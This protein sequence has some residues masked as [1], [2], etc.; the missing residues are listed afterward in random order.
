M[1]PFI[2]VAICFCRVMFYLSQ[3]KTM[4]LIFRDF[5]RMTEIVENSLNLKL[6]LLFAQFFFRISWFFPEP[7]IFT[8]EE[9]EK[10]LVRCGF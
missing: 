3:K 4:I 5:Q 8:W 1:I 10:W 2:F 6:S 9:Y 7:K